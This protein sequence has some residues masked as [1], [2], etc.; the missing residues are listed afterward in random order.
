MAIAPASNNSI[1]T[2]NRSVPA[3]TV[4][5]ME[6]ESLETEGKI[7]T[8]C[9]IQHAIL[10][11]GDTTI[12]ATAAVGLQI[13]ERTHEE[14][15]MVAVEDGLVPRKVKRR[16]YHVRSVM[17]TNLYIEAKDTGNELDDED[18]EA[19]C[20]ER[21]TDI[22][23]QTTTCNFSNPFK[24]GGKKPIEGNEI[25]T[26][27][28]RRGRA[29]GWDMYAS[30][31]FPLFRP[32]LRDLW[33]IAELILAFL[34]LVISTATVSLDQNQVFNIL[35]L[36]LIILTSILALVDG[37][38]T[39]GL[40]YC[41]SC[42]SCC[43]KTKIEPAS[44]TKNEPVGEEDEDGKDDSREDKDTVDSEMHKKG[45]IKG[46][47][48]SHCTNTTDIVRIVITEMLL[49]PLLIC[50]MF[51]VI[52]GKGYEGEAQNDRFGFALFIFSCISFVL[53]NYVARL[54]IL[55]GMI[56]SV[57]DVRKPSSDELRNRNDSS[58]NPSI[59]TSALLYQ[60]YLFIHV[61]LQILAQVLMFI[62]IGG[63]ILYDNRH[64]YVESNEDE[65]IYV[66][67]YLWYMIVVGYFLP[68]LGFLTFFLVTHYWSQEFPIAL[69]IDMVSIWKMGNP[70]DL[71][72]IDKIHQEKKSTV[73]KVIDQF[74]RIKKLEEDFQDLR[75]T[76]W[77]EKFG[78]PFKAP[79]LIVICV[80]YVG[81]H[82]GF[83]ICAAVAVNETGAIVSQILNGGGWAFYYIV[84]VLVSAI[85]N[86][87]VFAVAAL[88]IGVVVLIITIVAIIV[89][90]FILAIAVFC[91]LGIC[92]VVADNDDD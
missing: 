9:D 46:K 39:L 63:K 67:G 91:F 80:A 27:T 14:I 49:Y 59:R 23:C 75:K 30:A 86:A 62:A 64:F 47:C 5:D 70:D 73:L 52:T 68:L 55:A 31:I 89:A 34:G 81:L 83:V 69:C 11:A 25:L 24:R 76:H 22:C 65:S 13:E 36:A 56:K 53:Y 7:T 10:Q 18:V 3:L 1:P 42:K 66:S 61:L 54:L 6:E 79:V 8:H 20:C 19:T 21:C 58:Y 37:V 45:C 33:V 74:V 71:I 35:H 43:S 15:E 50:D 90:F 84:V 88:W 60:V 2:P 26:P 78:Y 32:A 92:A 57:Q 87:Y 40:K 85:A 48:C 17:L 44:E 29:K 77:C 41:R 12:R 16:Q 72:Y 4:I 28:L 82:L 51:E 38:F